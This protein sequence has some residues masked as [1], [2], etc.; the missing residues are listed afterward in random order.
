MTGRSEKVPKLMQS[1][2]DAVAAL[3]DGFCTEHLD[4]EYRQLARQLTAALCRKR[5]SPLAKGKPAAWA[6]GV[7]YALGFVNFLFDKSQEPHMQATEICQW[8]GVSSSSGAAK[9]KV[10]RDTLKMGQFDPNW[11]LPSKLKGNPLVWMISVNGF[12]IDVR[13][14]SRDVQE[15]A[16]R[17]GIIPYIPADGE[18]ASGQ[19]VTAPPPDMKAPIYQLKVTLKEIEPPIWRCVRVP[20]DYTLY[21]L[22]CVVQ[23]VMGWEECHLH[24]FVIGDAR[25]STLYDDVDLA[26]DVMEDDQATLAKVASSEGMKFT[27]VY[28]FGDDWKHEVLVQKILERDP[29]GVYPVC[30]GGE[31]ACPPEDCG[32]APGYEEFLEAIRDPEHEEHDPVLEWIGGSFDPEAFDVKAINRMLQKEKGRGY[33]RS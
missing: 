15:E 1:T 11:C 21:D 14:A 13:R 2:F 33:I 29:A 16:Y 27:Y 5:P 20:G 24:E 18:P 9:A 8:F 4:E 23:V 6:C 3:T 19:N 25:Y 30:L 12:V 26:E 22:H 17:K 32:G 31:R 28:D 10:I 7:V